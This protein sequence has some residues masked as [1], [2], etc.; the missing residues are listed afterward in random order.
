MNQ[1]TSQ[2]L[3]LTLETF[4][5]SYRP[6]LRSIC[7]TQDLGSDVEDALFGQLSSLEESL[8]DIARR[9]RW[10]ERLALEAHLLHSEKE[11]DL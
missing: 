4:L 9:L 8:L 10:Q 11:A 7:E 1:L 3:E 6:T 2:E 5:R